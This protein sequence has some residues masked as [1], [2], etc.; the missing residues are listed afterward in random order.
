MARGSVVNLEWR[1]DT[2]TLWFVKPVWRS[3][4]RRLVIA[5]LA[6]AAAASTGCVDDNPGL[7]VA[8]NVRPDSMC[9]FAPTGGA[10]VAYGVYDTAVV[11]PYVVAPLFR[12]G[13][14]S[15][16]A[17]VASPRAEP[18]NIA[19]EGAVVELTA[20]DGAAIPGVTSS[21]TVAMSAFVPTA[22]DG[23]AG[24]A[25]GL[26]EAIPASVG[27]ELAA[28]IAGVPTTVVVNMTFFGHTTGGTAIDSN[29]WSWTVQVCAGCLEVAC[30]TMLTAQCFGGQDGYPYKLSDCTTP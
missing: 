21:Y 23:Q 12:S 29:P 15:R 28:S 22:V 9:L 5:V 25:T 1:A 8:G 19:I 2:A 13:L 18:N 16:T 6:A 30:S 24:V 20:V 27:L 17:I 26:I 3:R 10:L 4:M 14:V 7:V 11:R